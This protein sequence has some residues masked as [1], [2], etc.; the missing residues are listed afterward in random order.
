MTLANRSD[1]YGSVAKTFHWLVAALIL[2]QW[3]LGWI[4][5]TWPMQSQGEIDTKVWLFSLHKTLGL[6][7]FAVALLRIL[8]A[9]TQPR[10]GLLRLAARASQR[11]PVAPT[12]WGK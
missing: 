2:T 11:V 12:R 3:P 6:A 4:A 5:A 9:L 1:R 10:P 7:I 8:W